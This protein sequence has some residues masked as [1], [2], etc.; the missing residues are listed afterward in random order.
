MLLRIEELGPLLKKQ[1]HKYE[2][3]NTKYEMHQSEFQ[4]SQFVLLLDEI[5]IK[6]FNLYSLAACQFINLLKS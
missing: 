1:C 4:T 2:F 6:N 5:Y 3:R